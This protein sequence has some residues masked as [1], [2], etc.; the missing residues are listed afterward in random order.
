M[1]TKCT[2]SEFCPG[3]KKIYLKDEANDYGPG[4]VVT[5]LTNEETLKE[6]MLG[7]AYKKSKRDPGIL[8]NFCP[9]CGAKLGDMR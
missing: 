1:M 2:K 6:T 8:V 3:L 7:V 9:S 5:I 4:M